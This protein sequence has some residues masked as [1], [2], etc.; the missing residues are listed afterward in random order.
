[1][2]RFREFVPPGGFSPRLGRLVHALEDLRAETAALA[3][4]L[5]S[6]TLAR[7]PFEGGNS[8]GTLLVH[9]AEAEA[10]WILERIGG[11]PLS[12][13][14]RELYRMDLFGRSRASQAQRAPASFFLG[15]LADLRVE[16]REILAAL[17]DGD[18]DGRRTW[19]DPNEP[20]DQEVFT[21]GWILIH[22]YGHESHHQGQIAMIRRMLGIPGPGMHGGQTPEAESR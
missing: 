22:L 20:S 14:R 11:R 13:E 12:R 5:E 15:L 8:I 2:L 19:I 6:D 21:V 3:A 4:N 16:S 1:M 17:R 9:I 10:F 7:V 18:M